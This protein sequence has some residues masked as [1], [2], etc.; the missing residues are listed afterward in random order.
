[1]KKAKIIL[2]AVAFFAVVGGALAFKTSRLVPADVWT[3]LPGNKISSITV[4][5]LVYSTTI[6][7][8]TLL[9]YYS[10][11]VGTLTTVSSTTTSPTVTTI[12]TR[13]GGQQ[14]ITTYH[15]CAPFVTRTAEAD[16]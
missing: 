10:T 3:L 8:C 12:F 15:Y 2:G 1:M 16:S 4:G 5:S 9:P 6:P 14:V 11:N 7:N 13:Q